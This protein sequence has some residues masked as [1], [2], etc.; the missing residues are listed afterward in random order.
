MRQTGFGEQDILFD[1]DSDKYVVNEIPPVRNQ[2][3]VSQIIMTKPIE[4]AAKVI[5]L[6]DDPSNQLDFYNAITTAPTFNQS[7]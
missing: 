7:K 3:A 4:A 1:G 6:E 5:S 2:E